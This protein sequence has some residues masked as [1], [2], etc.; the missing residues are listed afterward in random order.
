M[1]TP[2]AVP[3]WRGFV[4]RFAATFAL[5]FGM[6]TVFALCVTAV[7]GWQEHVESQWPQITAQ[8]QGCG[9]ELY[10]HKPEAYRID[11]AIGYTARGKDFVSQIH[12]RT[13]AAPRRV[14]GKNPTAAID[15]MQDWVDDHP[16]GTPIVVHYDP[17]NPEKTVLVTT[18]MPGGG[19]KTPG[20]LKLLGFAAASF[21][22]LSLIVLIAKPRPVKS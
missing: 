3:R 16:Q 9:V 17:A 20:N 1:A 15:R 22:V 21:V 12:S 5:L 18:D 11:C 19:P 4:L 2:A 13:T 7:Q 6:C 8:V 14:L 10:T